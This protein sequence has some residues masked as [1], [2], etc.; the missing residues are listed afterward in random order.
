MTRRPERE[1]EEILSA[2]EL[3]ELRHNLAHLS[4]SHVQDFYQLAHEDCRMIYT[5]L[6]S[7]KAIQT[8]VQVWKQLWMW[9]RR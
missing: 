3:K 2:E 8:L 9:R 6:P 4:P 1:K 5:R 7:P